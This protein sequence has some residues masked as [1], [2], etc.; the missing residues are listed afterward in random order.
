MSV[1]Q[2]EFSVV[3]KSDVLP[4]SCLIACEWL[5]PEKVQTSERQYKTDVAQAMLDPL[6]LLTLIV[7][8]SPK[9]LLPLIFL[10]LTEEA[11]FLENNG[12]IY[13]KCYCRHCIF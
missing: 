5:F 3:N 10:G 1:A 13:R 6:L 8:L 9:T 11:T 7:T 4:N 2:D 12:Q